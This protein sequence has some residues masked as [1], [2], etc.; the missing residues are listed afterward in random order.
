MDGICDVG[1]IAYYWFV[2]NC[3]NYQNFFLGINGKNKNNNG[4]G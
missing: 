2:V 4:L 3:W 1:F